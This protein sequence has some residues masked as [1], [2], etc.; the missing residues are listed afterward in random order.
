[1]AGFAVAP[2]LVAG[3]ILRAPV[4]D[5]VGLFT[6]GLALHCFACIVND[7]ADLPADR[8]NPSR[9]K[10]AL[11]AGSVSQNEATYLCLLMLLGLA[12]FVAAS[13]G[14]VSSRLELVALWALMA[15]GNTYQKRSRR[16]PPLVMD[17]LCG[18]ALA[19][20][21]PISIALLG[22]SINATDWVLTVA[23]GLQLSLA[24]SVAGNLKDLDADRLA[25]LRTVAIAAEVFL[26]PEGRVNA[27][28]AYKLYA[29]AMELLMIGALFLAMCTARC[30]TITFVVSLSVV[31]PLVAIAA[32][33]LHVL[34][35]GKRRVSQQGRERF[36]IANAVAFLGAACPSVGLYAGATLLA[37]IFAWTYLA[38]VALVLAS[39]GE[40]TVG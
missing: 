26:T 24:N 5:L 23:Y 20:P 1:M 29:Q 32:R 37:V 17:Q 13:R 33:D 40:V 8:A 18:V 35:S 28:S 27:P 38:T 21:L 39:R 34:V 4:T 16:V 7:L 15:Y 36:M 6:L 25:G 31:A 19:A 12:A 2:Y 22:G 30:T 10:S 9:A 3:A 11:V 14:P